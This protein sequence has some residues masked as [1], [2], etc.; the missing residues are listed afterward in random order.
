MSP[1]PSMWDGAQCRTCGHA[2]VT[3]RGYCARCYQ[4]IRRG[5]EPIAKLK[6]SLKG[7][8]RTVF[9][10]PR[11]LLAKLRKVAGARGM[12]VWVAEA[13][14]AKL[15]EGRQVAPQLTSDVLHTRGKYKKQAAEQPPPAPQPTTLPNGARTLASYR[16]QNGRVQS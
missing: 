7:H 10:L 9:R 3:A 12:S 14:E 5:K 2:K 13:I 4:Q 15:A 1:P 6:P 11:G 16:A 8:T